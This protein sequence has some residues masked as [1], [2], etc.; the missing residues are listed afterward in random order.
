MS[1]QDLL[2]I[3]LNTVYWMIL[4][5]GFV[6]LFFAFI[7]DGLLG[8][9]DDGS[10]VPAVGVFM[11]LFGSS[12]IV[13]LNLLNLTDV[14]SIFLGGVI[15]TGGAVFFYFGLWKWLKQQENTLEDRHENLVGKT[16]EVTL[17][18]TESSLGQITYSTDSGRTSAPA[19]SANGET[20][21]QGETVRVL[22]TA[23]TTFV[24]EVMKDE[25]NGGTEAT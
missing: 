10:L 15:S 13:G 18:M 24:V 16:A 9:G 6:V 2:G 1:F 4:G 19:K 25:E 17:T 3:D 23:G 11:G 21:R 7:F 8:F 22:R 14:A 20:I 5:F 12:G